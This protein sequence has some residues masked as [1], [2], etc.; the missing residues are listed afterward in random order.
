MAKTIYIKTFPEDLHMR[1]K[2]QAV[3]EQTSLKGLIIRALEEYLEK[4]GG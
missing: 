4:V 2:L 3:K 1:A